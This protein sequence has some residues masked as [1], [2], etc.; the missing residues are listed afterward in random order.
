MLQEAICVPSD[1]DIF[2]HY[3][4]ALTFQAICE[5][6]AI[7]FS[8]ATT[9]NDAAEMTWGLNLLAEASPLLLKLKDTI[10]ELKDLDSSFLARWALL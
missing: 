2:Y 1:D 3:C 9:M 8:D 10:P 4:S 7:R 5:S 6:K